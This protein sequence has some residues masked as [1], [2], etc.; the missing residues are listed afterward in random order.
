LIR[1]LRI[2]TEIPQADLD[3][4]HRRLAFGRRDAQDLADMQAAG[5]VDPVPLDEVARIGA[6]VQRNAIER[7]AALDLVIAGG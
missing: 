4:L 3:H 1:C 6:V 2:I 7:V 5:V